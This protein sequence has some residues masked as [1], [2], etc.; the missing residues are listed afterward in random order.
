LAQLKVKEITFDDIDGIFD[1][2]TK[3][4]HPYGANR[5]VALLSK[6]FNLAINKGWR[7]DNPAK[8]IERNEGHKRERYPSDDE[9]ARLTKTLD[10]WPDQT[11]ARRGEVLSAES[12]DLSADELKSACEKGGG[13]YMG[14]GAGGAYGC[15]T[16]GGDLV[17]CD[18]QV[19]KGQPYCGCT[20]RSGANR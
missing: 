18:G 9:R 2:I 15:L 7:T 11:G 14:P 20:A 16:K 6:M 13:V 5:V 8:G 1:S 3:S 10:A 12:K 4:G 19:P 17:A